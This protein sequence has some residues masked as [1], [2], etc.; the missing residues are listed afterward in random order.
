MACARIRASAPG[1][2]VGIVLNLS[3]GHP[4][5]SGDADRE[6]ARRF[7]GFFNRWYLDPLFRGAYPEDA[8]ADRVRRGHLPSAELPFLRAGDEKTI[9]E[10]LDFLGVNYYSRT[11]VK[12]GPGGEPV[13]APAAPPEELT[14]M[15]WEVY[16]E[17]LTQ[18][19]GRVARDYAPPAIYVTE[20]GAAFP[21]PPASGGPV[22]DARRT[23]YIESHVAA[24]HRAVEAGVPL[25]GYFVWSLLDNWEWGN[26]F[27]KRFG[28][29][30]VDEATGARASKRS[31]HWYRR[32]VAARGIA[33]DAI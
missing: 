13:G 26:G 2:D 33:G 8:V 20:N 28:L 12:A 3:P 24:A 22:D 25:R 19:L 11:T 4:A 31:A 29:F 9:A 15:G 32:A 6:A 23:A 16:P 18:I 1:G 14:D 30:G 7:D 27:T 5:T 21:D 10:P 17:G